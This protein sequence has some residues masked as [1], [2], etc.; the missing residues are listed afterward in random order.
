MTIEQ[1]AQY[2]GVSQSVVRAAISHRTLHGVIT[3]P[4]NPEN[5]MV[6]Q[7]DVDRWVATLPKYNR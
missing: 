3:D 5:W 1:I 2:A 4:N 6:R 7:P